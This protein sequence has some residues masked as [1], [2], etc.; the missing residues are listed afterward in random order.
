[1]KPDFL[2]IGA[3]KCGTTTICRELER[4]PEV[5]LFPNKETHFFSFRYGRGLEWYEG[6]FEG[7]KGRVRGEG[8][9]SYTTGE[10][11]ALAAERI[12]SDLPTSSWS[13]SPATPSVASHPDTSSSSTATSTLAPSPRSWRVR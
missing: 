8:S 11:S 1:M 12:A 13:S 9:P 4:H 7:L 5:G 10:F 6:L 3:Q 2:V